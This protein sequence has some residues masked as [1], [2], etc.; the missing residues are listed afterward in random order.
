MINGLSGE[1]PLEDA[2]ECVKML[3]M[4]GRAVPLGKWSPEIG[5][6]YQMQA[7]R[8]AMESLF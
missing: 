8:K 4:L 5:L 6:Y 1:M 3:T 2:I 7:N